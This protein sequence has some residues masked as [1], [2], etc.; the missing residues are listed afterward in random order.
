MNNSIIN[1]F[2]AL[3]SELRGFML[4]NTFKIRDKEKRKNKMIILFLKY[5]DASFKFTKKLIAENMNNKFIIVFPIIKL[6][7]K[8]VNIIKKSLSLL[9]TK[10]KS[11]L[12]NFIIYFGCGGRI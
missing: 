4:K 11:T 1:I 7:G 3:G 8:N 12:S 9:F 5:L 6:K 10:L 2:K